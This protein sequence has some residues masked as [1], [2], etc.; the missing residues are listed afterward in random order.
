MRF[1]PTI[2][3]DKIVCE[4][5]SIVLSSKIVMAGWRNI[6]NGYLLLQKLDLR[7]C[8]IIT[9]KGWELG[10]QRRGHRRKL[11]TKEGGGG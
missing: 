9:Q 7:D 4:G 6:D 5:L 11:T 10:N 2:F 3:L 1:I 8:A